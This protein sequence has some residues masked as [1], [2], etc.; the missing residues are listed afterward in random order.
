[1]AARVD[2]K[3]RPTRINSELRSGPGSRTSPSSLKQSSNRHIHKSPAT[4]ATPIKGRD[5]GLEYRSYS[6]SLQSKQHPAKGQN[7]PSPPSSSTFSRSRIPVPNGQRTPSPRPSSSPSSSSPSSRPASNSRILIPTSRSRSQSP[8][9]ASDPAT[10]NSG[11]RSQNQGMRIS[12]LKNPASPFPSPGKPK[13]SGPS[14]Q[15]INCG[16]PARGSQKPYNTYC[17]DVFDQNTPPPDSPLLGRSYHRGSSPNPPSSPPPKLSFEDE[18]QVS[19]IHQ[20]PPSM[21]PEPIRLHEDTDVEKGNINHDDLYKNNISEDQSDESEVRKIEVDVDVDVDTDEDISGDYESND[22]DSYVDEDDDK[23]WD[24]SPLLD[25]KTGKLDLARSYLP[26]IVEDKEN[27]S[28]YEELD[29]AAKHQHQHPKMGKLDQDHEALTTSSGE[30][31]QGNEDEE[32]E[33]WM[34]SPL[35]N[36]RTGKIDR[37]FDSWYLEWNWDEYFATGLQAKS[38]SSKSTSSSPRN[39]SVV[40]GTPRYSDGPHLVAKLSTPEKIL[41]AILSD[42]VIS[43]EDV[44][45]Q[46]AKI[47]SPLK[48][49]RCFEDIPARDIYAGLNFNFR[50]FF[51]PLLEVDDVFLPR[52]VYFDRIV[53]QINQEFW[54]TAPS[55]SRPYMMTQTWRNCSGLD[56]HLLRDLQCAYNVTLHKTLENVKALVPVNSWTDVWVE[57][58]Q[59]M[60]E[61]CRN[62]ECSEEDLDHIWDDYGIDLFRFFETQSILRSTTYSFKPDAIE[63]PSPGGPATRSPGRTMYLLTCLLSPDG[64]FK[65]RQYPPQILA[66]FSVRKTRAPAGLEY[67]IMP[68]IWHPHLS[69]SR[70]DTFPRYALTGDVSWL[71]W[72]QEGNCFRGEIPRADVDSISDGGRIALTITGEYTLNVGSSKIGLHESITARVYLPLTFKQESAC[73]NANI[74]DSHGHPITSVSLLSAEPR[75]SAV[76]KGYNNCVV[77]MAQ[78]YEKAI[79]D[80]SFA[81]KM[82]Q[83]QPLV[84]D[85]GSWENQARPKTPL[86]RMKSLGQTHWY[87]HAAERDREDYYRSHDPEA[88]KKLV[89]SL[90]D[91]YRQEPVAWNL[92]EKEGKQIQVDEDLE[93]MRLMWETRFNEAHVMLW[94]SSN[95]RE[96]ESER[97]VLDSPDDL[98]G[99]GF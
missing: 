2:S 81:N 15:P 28:R 82:V 5:T 30:K 31:D 29:K 39:N 53:R 33:F 9:N 8:K 35:L 14:S 61:F 40:I 91:G 83:K 93:Q 68:D 67:T 21:I 25:P 65:T 71:K 77:D 36:P 11:T 1:M 46:D 49:I 3:I 47:S 23:F 51:E 6:T 38:S 74:T 78:T 84:L 44:A 72:D 22:T 75:W 88:R 48:L 62:L 89:R 43:S 80:F 10:L 69:A 54:F 7:T 94:L 56:A 20:S 98:N 95:Y 32:D 19:E 79:E 13:T 97:L 90:S 60:D 92:D 96:E 55:N 41:E 86:Q 63:T 59:F 34:Q 73:D 16:K 52:T 85:T 45:E 17:Q 12:I 76:D 37:S 58:C 64:R 42:D 4:A 99:M 57:P 87:T 70:A 24:Q 27:E 66:A 26:T 18:E 50:S